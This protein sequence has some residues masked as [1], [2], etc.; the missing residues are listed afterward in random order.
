MFL[1]FSS[2]PWNMLHISS[3]VTEHQKPVQST[4]CTAPVAKRHFIWTFTWFLTGR[5]SSNPQNPFK[6]KVQNPSRP[7]MFGPTNETQQSDARNVSLLSLWA[8]KKEDRWWFMSLRHVVYVAVCGTL[9]KW[10]VT[11]DILSNHVP[12]RLTE[13][14]QARNMIQAAL[15]LPGGGLGFDTVHLKPDRMFL[16]TD[17]VCWEINTYF[18]LY[19][20]AWMYVHFL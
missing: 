17:T 15:A 5:A 8:D 4:V 3:S 2:V 13:A 7:F 20:T 18:R 19:A 16:G 10:S 14:K 6:V 12:A 9:K 11:G 1:F